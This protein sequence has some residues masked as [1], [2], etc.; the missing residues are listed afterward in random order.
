MTSSSRV[1]LKSYT[2]CQ[3]L[4]LITARQDRS[5][6]FTS[7][8]QLWLKM[9]RK[10]KL[11]HKKYTLSWDSNENS[12]NCKQHKSSNI[13]IQ[14]KIYKILCPKPHNQI[15]HHLFQCRQELELQIS[16]KSNNPVYYSASTLSSKRI[17]QF[18]IK[19]YW[20]EWWDSDSNA[21]R[22]KKSLKKL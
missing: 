8:N 20:N 4:T 2:I 9:S 14:H 7:L 18:Q 10:L 5:S 3:A 11:K 19:I 22:P 21:N 17:K 13:T 1:L 15:N 6:K 12:P 16:L